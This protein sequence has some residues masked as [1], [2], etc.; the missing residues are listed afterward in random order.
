MVISGTINTTRFQSIKRLLCFYQI[1]LIR[2]IIVTE[3]DN[4][5][6]PAKLKDR[7][8]T[9]IRQL[10]RDFSYP[11][12]ALETGKSRLNLSTVYDQLKTA[13]EKESTGTVTVEMIY[14]YPNKG[15]FFQNHIYDD[16]ADRASPEDTVKSVEKLADM[17]KSIFEAVLV[18]I[19]DPQ[20]SYITFEKSIRYMNILE[21]LDAT[22]CILGEG[23]EVFVE[24]DMGV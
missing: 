22:F 18:Y 14:S 24:N 10:W 3:N 16:T 17:I 23:D 12:M 5:V 4:P 13:V 21:L 1:S 8:T 19:A 7:L 9:E 6:S 15:M 20:A 11:D 2:S